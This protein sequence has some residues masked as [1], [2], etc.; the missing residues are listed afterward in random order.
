MITKASQFGKSPTYVHYCRSSSPQPDVQFQC[1]NQT[2]E[3]CSRFL[4]QSSVP[5]R[6]NT[7]CN[8][9]S[10]C[11]VTMHEP[12][13]WDRQPRFSR[14]V[15]QETVVCAHLV[16]HTRSILR[17]ISVRIK[18]YFFALMLYSPDGHNMLREYFRIGLA[19]SIFP[20]VSTPSSS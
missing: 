7:V 8:T 6:G 3:A 9:Q 2:K 12:R 11:C 4:L 5:L 16:V 18:T 15:V 13:W 20:A 10:V 14:Y 19:S 1:L 17:P